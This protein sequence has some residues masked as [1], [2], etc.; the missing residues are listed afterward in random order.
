MIEGYEPNIIHQ[1]LAALEKAGYIDGIITQNIDK[2]HQKAGS[3]NVAEIHGD[4]SKYYCTK[5]KKEYSGEEYSKNGYKCL[6]PGCSGMIRPGIVLYDERLN[7]E[8]REKAEELAFNADVF[9]V[10]GSSLTVPTA[11]NLI[12]K[13]FAGLSSRGKGQSDELYIFTKGETP[14]DR[15][16]WAQ[17]KC[18]EDLK[19]VFEDINKAFRIISAIK[20]LDQIYE[21]NPQTSLHSKRLQMLNVLMND[22]GFEKNFAL[23]ILSNYTFQV[24]NVDLK[25]ELRKRNKNI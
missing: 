10:L 16:R 6:E 8:T 24:R 9:I 15:Y 5:C 3:K 17:N 4:G 25:K 23:N 11:Q 1:T 13:Y 7:K 19:E 22:F 21:S 14:Y 18:E 2:L 12:A 20:I